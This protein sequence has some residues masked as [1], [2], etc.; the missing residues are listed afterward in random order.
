MSGTAQQ[1]VVCTIGTKVA[2]D[3][4]KVF[5][6]S[7]NLFNSS[8]PTIYLL[9]DT[10][11]KSR[12]EK[13]KENIYKG[14]LNVKDSLESYASMNRQIMERTRGKRYKTL[15]EDF[16]MEKATVLE[17]AFKDGAKSAFFFDS[18]ITF[19]STLPE[20]PASAKLALSPHFI[21][22][23]DELRYGHYNA[24]FV[25]TSDPAMPEKWRSA[26]ERSRYYDQAALEELRFNEPTTYEFP[27]QVN[28]GW[29]RMFQGTE[30]PD[31]LKSK[32]TIFRNEQVPSVG[33]RV[34]GKP[35]NSVHTHWGEKRDP[36][37]KTFNL[38]LLQQIQKISNHPKA[39]SFARFIVREF[40]LQ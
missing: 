15:W 31:V 39:A 6:F 32:W 12:I 36:V 17:W 11:T 25:W 34:E 18:D 8:P 26:A 9:C 22:P 28:Y 40:K 10:E 30:S 7:L 5:F 16:M 20:V 14:T 13:D 21:K 19:F 3:D 23:V 1:S 29:W 27:V 33:L 38:W 2:W 35:L 4:L 24:G 37:T